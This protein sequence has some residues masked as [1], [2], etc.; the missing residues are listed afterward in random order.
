MTHKK[1]ISPDEIANLLR[2]LSKNESD[3][4][5]L[6]CCN[7]D[8][9]KDIRLSE[10]DCEEHEERAEEIDNNLIAFATILDLKKTGLC[11]PYPSIHG[12]KL[13][14]GVVESRIRVLEPLK[15]CYMQGD[16]PPD[17]QACREITGLNID[18]LLLGHMKSLVYEMS[19]PLVDDLTVRISV[20]AGKTCDLPGI[21]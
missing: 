2:E 8:S 10:S 14:A 5:E 21:F 9:E 18:G 11:P 16:S 7:L 12:R 15:T 13:V 19:V 6:S 3:D 1:S 17:R 4:G 20:D